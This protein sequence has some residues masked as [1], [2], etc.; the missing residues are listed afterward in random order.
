MTTVLLTGFDPFAGD[1]AN[2]SG[3]AVRL[4]AERWSGDEELV[5]DVLPVTFEGAAARLR[6]LIA[7][8][9]PAVIVATGLAGGRT[10]VTPERVAIN[11]ADARIPDNGGAQPSDSPVVDGAPT[12]Y[13]ATL[14]VKA[15]AAA[16]GEVGIPSS[17][18]HTAGTFVCNHVM[19]TALHEVAGTTARAGFV[20]VPY[21][22]E[23]AP[24]GAP[25]LPL[26]DIARAL[27]VAVRTAIDTAV[28]TTAPGGSLH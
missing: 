9:R 17:V 12:A 3:D 8:H 18:S 2:P 5:V 20:H 27:E 7:A 28:D 4:V 23:T 22:R 26:D 16:L 15:I 19:F 24:A 6:D 10:A 11:L 13:F 25:S 14:P 1:A 21:A